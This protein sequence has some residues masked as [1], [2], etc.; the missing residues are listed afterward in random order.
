MFY[1]MTGYGKSTCSIKQQSY[2]LEIKTLNS[3]QLDIYLKNNQLLKDIDL[4][5]RKIIAQQAIRGKVEIALYESKTENYKRI[6]YTVLEN[7]YKD[8]QHFSAEKN[9]PLGDIFP[10]ILKMYDTLKIDSE[11]LSNEDKQA[12]LTAFDDAFIALNQYRIDEGNALKKDITQRVEI[13][14]NLLHTILP[15]EENRM[16]LIRKK[17]NTEL[18]QLNITADKDRLE[19]ELIY[20]IEKLD[21]TE[22]KTRLL[23]HCQYFIEIVADENLEKGKK[24]GFVAQEIGREINTIGSK[25]N[26]ANIQKIVV[27]MKDELEKIKEQLNNVL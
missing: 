3:K 25:A 8:L 10:T 24:L 14:K 15:F 11:T 21:I 7:M 4:D 2:T 9:I 12:I 19:Q 17:I 22:E 13:I 16:Q 23:L 27:L 26:D 6:N 20:Y 18:E 5:I 1:S